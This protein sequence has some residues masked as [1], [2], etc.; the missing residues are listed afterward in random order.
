MYGYTLYTD[1]IGAAPYSEESILSPSF[2]PAVL[3]YPIFLFCCF[4]YAISHQQDCM[5]HHL[6][7]T[8][9]FIPHTYAKSKGSGIV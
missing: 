9:M 1:F 7:E 3:H 5:V 6:Q 4:I 8:V 2:T